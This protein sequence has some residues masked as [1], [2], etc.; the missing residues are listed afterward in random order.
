MELTGLTLDRPRSRARLHARPGSRSRRSRASAGG[1]DARRGRRGARDAA[2]SQARQAARS[3]PCSTARASTRSCAARPTCPRPGG[4][5]RARAARRALPDG[6]EIGERELG[7]V[8]SRGMLCSERELDSAATS[9]GILV[10]GADDARRP[11]TP[12]AD[13]LALRDT[14]SRSSLTP[15][16]PDCLGPR[17]PRAR[18]VRAVRRAVCAAQADSAGAPGGG[19]RRLVPAA[20]VDLR[21][22][23]ASQDATGGHGASSP[24]ASTSPTARAAR[25]TPRRWSTA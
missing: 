20:R 3:S 13:A 15:N 8:V 11:G 24:C 10:L 19:G 21:P 25:A 18:A 7:G 5:V 1:L 6:L 16:R 9:D 17:R 12:L 22:A 2:A 14:V 23:S 4:R